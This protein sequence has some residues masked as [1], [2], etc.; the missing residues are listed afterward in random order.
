MANSIEIVYISGVWDLFHVGHLNVI[1]QAK[2]LGDV[3]IVGVVTDEFAMEYKGQLPL[4]PFEQRCAIVKSIQYVDV[5]VPV[6]DF[7]VPVHGVTI[8]AHG[9]GYGVYDGQKIVLRQLAD[10]G[11]RTVSI[12]RT[13]GVS[14]TDIIER[15][16][17]Q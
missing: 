9:P 2:A 15:I 10:L 13:P 4:I 8:R 7:N 14:T 16:K 6:R 12:P 17:G 11:I 5:V 1:W 3:L